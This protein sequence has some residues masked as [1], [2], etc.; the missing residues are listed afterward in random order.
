MSGTIEQQRIDE[1]R[2]LPQNSSKVPMPKVHAPR[3]EKAIVR[4]PRPR[5]AKSG[6][7]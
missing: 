1:G 6:R 3:A 2:Q 4:T 7:R 5:P